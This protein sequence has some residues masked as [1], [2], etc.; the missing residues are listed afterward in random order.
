M[1]GAVIILSISSKQLW[2]TENSKYSIRKK[3]KDGLNIVRRTPMH[4]IVAVMA[5]ALL[6]GTRKT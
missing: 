5:D 6:K 2:D 4:N 3:W 1:R